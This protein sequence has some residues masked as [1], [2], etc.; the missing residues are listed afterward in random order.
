MNGTIKKDI[1]RNSEISDHTIYT[2]VAATLPDSANTDGK[3][4]NRS[5]KTSLVFQKNAP[6]TSRNGVTNSRNKEGPNSTGSEDEI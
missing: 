6:S 1:P 3:R 4:Y 5:A 2:E